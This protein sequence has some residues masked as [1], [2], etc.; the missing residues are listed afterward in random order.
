MTKAKRTRVSSW[1]P[2]AL[3]THLTAEGRKSS[4]IGITVHKLFPK[5]QSGQGQF[6]WNRTS[7]D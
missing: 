1:S 3:E 5:G 6:E 2:Y 7:S 4:T